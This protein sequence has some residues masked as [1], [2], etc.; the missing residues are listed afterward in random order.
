MSPRQL[1]RLQKYHIEQYSHE[2][3]YKYRIIRISSI[4]NPSQ[5]ALWFDKVYI[6]SHMEK[7]S[8]F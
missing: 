6:C 3:N 2:T 4:K 8:E 1:T 7:F 5:T